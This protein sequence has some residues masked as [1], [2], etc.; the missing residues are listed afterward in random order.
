[1]RSDDPSPADGELVPF[2]VV[3]A[4]LTITEGSSTASR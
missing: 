2:Q 4:A 1:M 3:C